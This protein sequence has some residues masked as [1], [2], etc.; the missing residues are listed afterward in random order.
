MKTKP[1]LALLAAA[2][3]LAPAGLTAQPGYAQILLTRTPS[4][5]ATTSTSPA[6]CATLRTA[7][8]RFSVA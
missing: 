6:S 3:L 8:W 4:A 1:F 5:G 2:A 7:T